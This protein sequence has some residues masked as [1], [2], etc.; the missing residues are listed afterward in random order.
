VA[1]TTAVPATAVTKPTPAAAKPAT[2]VVTPVVATTAP[3]S[4]A[5]VKPPKDVSQEKGTI[6]I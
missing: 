4:V 5:T 6:L 2:V 3:V 1:A